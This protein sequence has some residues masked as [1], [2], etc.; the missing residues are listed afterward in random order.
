MQ[1]WW[2]CVWTYSARARQQRERRTTHHPLSWMLLLN[3]L[4]PLHKKV[5]VYHGGA[6]AA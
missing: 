3:V 1:R 5:R 2:V 4:L 6:A